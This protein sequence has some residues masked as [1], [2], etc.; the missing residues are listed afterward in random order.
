MVKTTY[1]SDLPW[2]AI[3]SIIVYYS[4]QTYYMFTQVK[5]IEVRSEYQKYSIDK[6]T[7]RYDMEL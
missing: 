1:K 5:N 7:I 6:S 3:F 4:F 2:S